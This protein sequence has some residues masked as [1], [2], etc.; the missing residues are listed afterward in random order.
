MV[1]SQYLPIVSAKVT[2]SQKFTSW[3]CC[4]TFFISTF[5]LLRHQTLDDAYLSKEIES[6]GDIPVLG[7]FP[8]LYAENIHNVYVQFVARGF[9]AQPC[10]ARMRPRCNAVRHDDVTLGN[11]L[12]QRVFEVRYRPESLLEELN[13]PGFTLLY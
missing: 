2:H 4:A 9:F 3:I 1:I 10:A 7:D 6:I 11:H 8:V 13:E 12:L 5:L